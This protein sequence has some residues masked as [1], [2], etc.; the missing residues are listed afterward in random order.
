M[1]CASH[2]AAPDRRPY[3]LLAAVGLL[4]TIYL[5]PSPPPLARAEAVIPLTPQGQACPAIMAFAVTLWVTETFPFAV[6]TSMI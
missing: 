6:D 5:L 4:M 2:P 3:I 1:T